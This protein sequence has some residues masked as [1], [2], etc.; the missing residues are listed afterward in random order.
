MQLA[1]SIAVV[2]VALSVVTESAEVSVTEPT[3][4]KKF[5]RFQEDVKT[6]FD[7]FGEKAKGALNDL[8][9]SKI[10]NKTRNWFSENFQK[11]RE[12]FRT[13]F[14]PRETD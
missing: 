10:S 3:L 6:F 4:S 1:I 14:N 7:N 9:N 13:T 5:E 8:H 2:L 12:K 11:L